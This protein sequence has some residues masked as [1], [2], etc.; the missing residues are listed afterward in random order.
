MRLPAPRGFTLLEL[1][2]SMAIMAVLIGLL[3]PA[4]Q[5]VRSAAAKISC[6]SRLRQIGLGMHQHQ[7]DHNHLPQG[8]TPRGRSES[9]PYLA[10]TAR[11]LPYIEQDNLW[12]QT[13]EAYRIRRSP[14]TTE[15][16]AKEHVVTLFIC[17]A[18]DRL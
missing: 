15:H 1:L 6:S 12:R 8:T 13:E 9:Y 16:M 11:L 5:K 3:L 18:D 10:Y 17:P 7:N 14:Y 2:V 4:V